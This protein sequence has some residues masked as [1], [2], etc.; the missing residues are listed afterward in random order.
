LQKDPIQ[1]LD[2]LYTV[3]RVFINGDEVNNKMLMNL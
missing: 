1:D 2:A 3:R